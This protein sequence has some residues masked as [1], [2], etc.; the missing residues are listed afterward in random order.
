MWETP[1]TLV[2]HSAMPP[3]TSG[4]WTLLGDA[5]W[6]PNNATQHAP[7]AL[8]TSDQGFPNESLI[9]IGY[10][11]VAMADTVRM[12]SRGACACSEDIVVVGDVPLGD[13]TRAAFAF[14]WGLQSSSH[15]FFYDLDFGLGGIDT[16]QFLGPDQSFHA[17]ASYNG[18]LA[19]VGWGLDS[20]CVHKEV[21][22]VR[23]VQGDNGAPW[24][25]FGTHG[26]VALD[27]PSGALNDTVN[28][29]MALHESGGWWEDVA[30]S[31]DGQSLFAAGAALTGN[32]FQP[33]LAKFKLDGTLD[34]TFESGGLSMPLLSSIQNHWLVSLAVLEDENV[35]ALL[36]AGPGEVLGPSDM[37]LLQ[38]GPGI[39][40]WEVHALEWPSDFTPGGIAARGHQ[41]AVVGTVGDV[42]SIHGE[43]QIAVGTFNAATSSW[44]GQGGTS[45]P[46]LLTGYDI[47]WSG[48]SA[49][50]VSARFHS[51]SLSTIN[52]AW[53]DGSSFAMYRFSP[54]P[55][56]T[57]ISLP[58]REAPPTGILSPNPTTDML[59]WQLPKAI[60][61]VRVHRVSGKW[62]TNEKISPPS[63]N[64]TTDVSK[65]GA[66]T[67]LCH[68]MNG[69]LV[70]ATQSVVV[71]QK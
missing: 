56:A 36:R 33:L 63:Q 50:H 39:D 27:L 44:S 23:V 66:G 67:Y 20:C 6:G 10:D 59:H 47:G 1:H 46:Y 34:T 52:A 8:S 40:G 60:T 14:K 38:W 45:S 61:E 13:S 57:S 42:V 7:F 62:V 25:G 9:F 30:W 29:G 37:M 53:D 54:A 3:S 15:P 48:D 12:M 31:S 70:V 16:L 71:A 17:C 22:L 5:L 41:V 65:W 18:Q 64:W 19:M 69:A 2:H 21:P 43:R 4:Q 26:N 35:V 28:S 32:A 24:P 11:G 51:D 58:Y 68:A 49:L 55:N